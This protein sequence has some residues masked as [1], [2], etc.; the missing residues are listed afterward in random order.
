MLEAIEV[1][2]MWLLS[3]LLL[4]NYHLAAQDVLSAVSSHLR[5][6]LIVD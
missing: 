1:T 2:L 3:E 6:C 4:A 5:T